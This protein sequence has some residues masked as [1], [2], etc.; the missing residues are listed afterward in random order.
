MPEC[1]DSVDNNKM[2]K[3]Q[4]LVA[5]DEK[6]IVQIVQF[7]L[8]KKGNYEVIGDE[9]RLEFKL[10]KGEDPVSNEVFKV[11]SPRAPYMDLYEKAFEKIESMI[12]S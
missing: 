9:L 1:R 8:E 12:K 3:T 4:I 10:F 6:H 5:D 7:N 11:T 2:T